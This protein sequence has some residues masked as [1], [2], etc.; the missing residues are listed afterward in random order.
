MRGRD[1]QPITAMTVSPLT[2]PG[3]RIAKMVLPK[4]SVVKPD[5]I[6][7]HRRMIVIAELEIARPAPVISSSS[8][9]GTV[10][11]SRQEQRGHAEKSPA[12][13][14]E[15]HRPPQL[16]QERIVAI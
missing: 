10:A 15:A 6:G 1:S 11:A 13:R 3:R 9:G 4:S 5:Q 12:K 16:I 7:D 14:T 8:K 2:T